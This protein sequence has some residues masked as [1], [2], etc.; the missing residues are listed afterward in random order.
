MATC[1]RRANCLNLK[2]IRNCP[3]ETTPGLRFDLRQASNYLKVKITGDEASGRRDN[4][5]AG[6]KSRRAG[7]RQV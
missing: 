2:E 6:P 4:G 1:K 7:A 5:D 3:A